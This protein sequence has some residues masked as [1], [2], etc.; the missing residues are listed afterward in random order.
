MT[1]YNAIQRRASLLK[2][3]RDAHIAYLW[4]MNVCTPQGRRATTL[5]AKRLMERTRDLWK[6]GAVL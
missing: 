6:L 3:I 4:N 2:A 1:K 5:A